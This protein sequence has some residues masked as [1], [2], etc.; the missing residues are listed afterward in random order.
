MPIG[1]MVGRIREQKYVPDDLEEYFGTVAQW[2][3]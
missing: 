2:I 3:L 1:I